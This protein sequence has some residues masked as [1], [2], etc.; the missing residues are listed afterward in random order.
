MNVYK[1]TIYTSLEKPLNTVIICNP[2][3][4]KELYRGP[5]HKIPKTLFN[6]EVYARLYEYNVKTLKLWIRG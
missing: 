3:I 4:K 1:T 5:I 6:K 2:N